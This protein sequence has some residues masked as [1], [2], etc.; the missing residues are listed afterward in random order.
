MDFENYISVSDYTVITAFLLFLIPRKGKLSQNLNQLSTK[1]TMKKKKNKLPSS[2]SIKILYT[3]HSIS[4]LFIILRR[5]FKKP[6]FLKKTS[7][8]KKHIHTHISYSILT[9]FSVV[10]GSF[11]DPSIRWKLKWKSDNGP[12]STIERRILPI[13][14]VRE[15]RVFHS[16]VTELEGCR[17]GHSR[18]EKG[19]KRSRG[20]FSG[21]IT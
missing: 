13:L 17:R 5:F 3:F 18:V 15:K 8:N 19:T 1:I 2:I 16:P 4:Q 10:H 7:N 6:N 14:L 20:R 12:C 9:N 11:Q 21:V